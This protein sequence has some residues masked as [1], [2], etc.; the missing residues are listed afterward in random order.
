[1][2]ALVH[3]VISSTPQMTTVEAQEVRKPKRMLHHVQLDHTY[4][5]RELAKLTNCNGYGK[6]PILLVW[7]YDFRPHFRFRK[8]IGRWRLGP[9]LPLRGYLSCR[10]YLRSF[11]STAKS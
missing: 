8:L 10:V 4:R 11:A 7:I 9:G 2:L 1:M 5:T 3:N 6:D